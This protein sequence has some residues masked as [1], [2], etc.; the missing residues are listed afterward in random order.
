M[1]TDDK[2]DLAISE[3]RALRADFEPIK[4]RVEQ[5]ESAWQTVK[6]GASVVAWATGALGVCAT[7]LFGILKLF[8]G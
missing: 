2:L 5:A 6:N 7:I 3:V 8:L 1:T 4:L